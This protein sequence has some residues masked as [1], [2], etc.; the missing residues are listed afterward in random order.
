MKK[1]HNLPFGQY[2]ITELLDN[3]SH[4]IKKGASHVHLNSDIDFKKKN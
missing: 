2:P 1:V 3:I 4:A